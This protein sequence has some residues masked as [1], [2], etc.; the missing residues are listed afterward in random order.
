MGAKLRILTL[1]LDG[2][3]WTTLHVAR[4][5]SGGRARIRRLLCHRADLVLMVKRKHGIEAR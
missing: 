1:L 2:R 5:T 4:L 3:E